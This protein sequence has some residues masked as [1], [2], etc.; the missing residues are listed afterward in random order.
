MNRAADED[1]D[2]DD[3]ASDDESSLA[4][5][6]PTVLDKVEYKDF[7][8][9]S[10]LGMESRKQLELRPLYQRGYKWRVEQ[11]SLWVESILLGYHCPEIILV[12]TVDGYS[13]LDGQQ[14]LTSLKLYVRG[15]KAPSWKHPDDPFALKQIKKL[16]HLDGRTYKQLPRDSQDQLMYDFSFRCAIIP[17]TWPLD[18]IIDFFKRI[19]G[20]GTRMSNQEL[21][22]AMSRGEFTDLLD[23]LAVTS[24]SPLSSLREA[25]D[26]NKVKLAADELQELLLRFFMLQ[27]YSV[28]QFGVPNM[29]EHGLKTMQELN[30]KMRSRDGARRVEEV[31]QRLRCAVEVAL[32]VFAVPDTLFRRAMPL[33]RGQ[34]R[35]WST[36]AGINKYIWDC[37][38]SAFSVPALKGAIIEN[39]FVV[40]EVLV[41]LMQTH[42]AFRALA[43]A[44]TADRIDAVRQAVARVVD[45]TAVDRP[46]YGHER[47]MILAAA[48]QRRLP[49]AICKQSL[50][51][52]DDLVHIDHIVPRAQGGATTLDNLQVAH[53]YCNL[54]KGAS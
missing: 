43:K 31:H 42:P 50:P 44:G 51:F 4:S 47:R 18:S 45:V 25:L 54:V 35:V 23:Q 5:L 52:A 36:T 46:L 7:G 8:L 3:E 9:D 10:L 26:A 28:N 19:Q 1:A 40:R 12:R 37:F 53:K 20:G 22:R 39:A 38:L 2:M 17:K 21:R 34:Q 33:E 15:E 14:R 24:A 11:A 6:Q 30:D 32:H 27:F 49:C 16:K 48:R 13:V 29:N 41:D